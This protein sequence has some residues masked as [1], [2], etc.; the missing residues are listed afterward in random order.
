MGMVFMA[1]VVW[2]M[3]RHRG[4]LLRTGR[5]GIRGKRVSLLFVDD[6]LRQQKHQH[7]HHGCTGYQKYLGS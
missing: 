7:H 6:D 3:I 5:A 2:V 1:L 4:H